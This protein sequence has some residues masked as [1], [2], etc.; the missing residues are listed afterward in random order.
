MWN[1]FESKG[2]SPSKTV[3]LK[4]GERICG[5]WLQ[6]GIR[7]NTSVRRQKRAQFVRHEEKKVK[8]CGILYNTNF[9]GRNSDIGCYLLWQREAAV[10]RILLPVLHLCCSGVHSAPGLRKL[11]MRIVKAELVG[12][13][14]G[15]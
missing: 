4:M 7:P 15:N 14:K 5:G 10:P 3:S 1:S 8:I 11:E 13:S 12:P 9:P 6:E 2:Q